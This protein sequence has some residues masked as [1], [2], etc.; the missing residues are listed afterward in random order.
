MSISL[1]LSALA[2]S[3]CASV[4]ALAEISI[5][6]S[7]DGRS[8]VATGTQAGDEL[9]VRVAGD[10]DL[11]AMAG[12]LEAIDGRLRFTS[13]FPIS[14]GVT[15][16][17]SVGG[18]ER[19]FVIPELD[20]TPVARVVGVY[21]SADQLPENL[22]K[23]YLHFSAPM[24]VGEASAH[25]RLL[26]SGGERVP[27]P[28]LDLAEEL[29]DPDGKR[30]T[31]FFDP[32]RVKRG[33]KPHE[34]EGRALLEGRDYELQID[35]AW[36]DAQGRQ[37]V[38]DYSK[39]F[40]AVAA[41]YTQPDA[42]K[43][44]VEAPEAGTR[45]PLCLKFSEPLDHS[46]LERVLLVYGDGGVEQVGVVEIGEGE[47]EWRWTPDQEWAAG[48]YRIVVEALLE[49]MAGNSVARLFEE[50]GGVKEAWNVSGGRF[51]R[52]PFVVGDK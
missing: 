51:I 11:P 14:P 12:E 35:A 15:Y 3:L 36:R 43:W 40:R 38:G 27:L 41:D 10:S 29:W 17:A 8:F 37:M 49:D 22:L 18:I 32:G 31:L 13:R 39:R 7:A 21:P 46:L 2:L 33:L 25:V 9:R 50:V 19:E 47:T 23:F 34:E 20:P 52:V 48:S 1:R 4:S 24:A 44:V 30:L 45:D 28:F 6:L 5:S 16:L 26:G 42:T